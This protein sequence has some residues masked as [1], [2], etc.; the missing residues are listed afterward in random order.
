MVFT[1]GCFLCWPCS[2]GLCS[3]ADIIRLCIICHLALGNDTDAATTGAR[4]VLFY[5]KAKQRST[6]SA[7]TLKYKIKL[8]MICE[9]LFKG[10]VNN[11][12]NSVTDFVFS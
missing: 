4:G 9:F 8:C 3:F 7:R 6:T 12:I 10:V 11:G 5:M 1:F 2:A